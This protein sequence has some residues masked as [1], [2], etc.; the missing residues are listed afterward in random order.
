[1][2]D[3]TRPITRLTIKDTETGT[4]TETDIKTCARGVECDEG[5]TVQDHISDFNNPH[6][7]TYDQVGAAA[8]SHTHSGSDLTSAV[9]ISKG[10]T[11]ATEAETALANLGGLKTDMSNA[12]LGLA[13]EEGEMPSSKTWYS[14]CY[15]G[16]K[17]VA[18]AQNSTAAAYSADGI[19]WTAATLPQNAYW[20][21]VCYGG[22]KFVAVATNSNAAAYSADGINWTA[23]TLPSSKTWHSVCYGGGKF[24]VV[25]SGG[26]KVAYSTDGIN[27][28][29]ATLPQNAYWHSACYGDGKFVA[30]ANGSNKVAYADATP[31]AISQLNAVGLARIQTL[32]YVGTGTFGSDNQTSLT[33]DFVPGVVMIQ[34]TTSELFHTVACRGAEIV[35][36]CE[37]NGETAFVT[38]NG[39]TML[40][41]SYSSEAAQFNTSGVTYV[42]VAIG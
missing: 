34:Q 27:W 6:S 23:A 39:K 15:G 14:V 16:G 29:A 36:T 10:G 31:F 3:T 26:N 37:F 13:W 19:N 41:Y 8:A 5:R 11:G 12:N 20:D 24:V 25:A 17:F 35:Y 7:V 4:E 30:V 42:A 32:T 38:W 2:A 18:V 28:T 1:M 40:I 21:S 33:F 22:G 9:P